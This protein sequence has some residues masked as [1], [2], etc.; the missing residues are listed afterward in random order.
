MSAIFRKLKY[1]TIFILILTCAACAPSK[2]NNYNPKRRE[3][4]KVNT[5]QLGRNKYYY[6]PGYKKKLNSSYKRVK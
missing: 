6:S 2:K 1:I 5:S 4:S 3:A